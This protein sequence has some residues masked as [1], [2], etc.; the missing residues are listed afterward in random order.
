LL[1][2]AYPEAPIFQ[3]KARAHAAVHCYWIGLSVPTERA[4]MMS[5]ALIG[6]NGEVVNA[7]EEMEGVVFADLDR[8]DPDFDVALYKAKP[9]RASISTNPAYNTRALNDLRNT[10]RTIY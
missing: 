9:W 10:N 8:S 1:L 5:S 7:I 2:S 4:N 6:P 3:F